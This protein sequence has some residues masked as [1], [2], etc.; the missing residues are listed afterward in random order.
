MSCIRAM[1]YYCVLE[2]FGE[3]MRAIVYISQETQP[4]DSEGLR[5]LL[6][7]A[8][9]ANR[10]SG[11]TGYLHYESGY[12][13]Q[14]IEGE[15]G[16]LHE[17][18]GRISRDKR[19]TIFYRAEEEETQE[20]RF[21]DWYM[22]WEGRDSATEFGT[23]ISELT[24]TLKPLEQLHKSEELERAFSLYRQIAYDHLLRELVALK[25]QNDEVT[26]LLSMAVH[27]LRTPVRSITSLLEMYIEDAGDKIDPEF[28][29]VAEFMNVSLARMTGLVD[30]ILEHF[31][32]D[33]QVKTELV[34][35]GELVDEI[36]KATL[37]NERACE[38]VKVG[39]FPVFPANPLRL[40]R[41]LNCLITNGLKY[42]QSEKRRV[43]ISVELDEPYWQF[44]VQDNGIG[45]HPKHQQRIFEIFQRLH[46]QSD[47]QGTGVGLA[48]C[49]K[50]VEHWRG[51]IWIASNEGE[52]SRFYFTHPAHLGG[53]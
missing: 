11:V 39:D 4:F 49:R 2:N 41:V 38:V 18:I 23:A 45:I 1:R 26:G 15:V 30:G 10:E 35:T 33:A 42:N 27:D 50:L 17:T 53:H 44:C 28:L 12:F 5:E 16:P 20:R 22:G 14:Y 6:E 21:P 13:L 8:I 19:H 24:R 7:V 46:N 34:D 29:D 40:W 47:Y 52:G 43:E 48:T 31:E 37:N 9:S 36:A 32:T 3:H 51:K 25:S